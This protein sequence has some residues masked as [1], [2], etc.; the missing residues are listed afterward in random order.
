MG[1]KVARHPRTLTNPVQI[2]I[3]SLEMAVTQQNLLSDYL[4]SLE[5]AVMLIKGR[6]RHRGLSSLAPARN[7]Q[8]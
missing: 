7:Q 5:E 6:R 8:T 2:D 4:S 1:G 3:V